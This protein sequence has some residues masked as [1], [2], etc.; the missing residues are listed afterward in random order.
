MKLIKIILISL[1]ILLLCMVLYLK[2]IERT[3]LIKILGKSC[4]IVA[5]G[6]MEPNILS[7]EF[8]IIEERDSY[9]EGDIITYIDEDG[10]L[11]THRIV[12]IND[13]SFVS[14]GDAN[15]INDNPCNKDRIQ[16]KVIFHSICLG[17]FILYCLKPVCIL[18]VIGIMIIEIISYERRKVKIET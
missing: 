10:F 18:Y 12:E 16:G 1:M 9:N 7:E 5:T 4:L 8:I 14:K 13:S 2:Y 11:I 15:N 3:P 6:S 17:K